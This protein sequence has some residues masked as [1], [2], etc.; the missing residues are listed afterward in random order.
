M[1]RNKMDY[2]IIIHPAEEG[3]YWVEVPALS[4]CY[5][6]GETIEESLVN[7]KDAIKSHICVLKEEGKR[8]PKDQTLVLSHIQV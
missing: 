4:G 6:Q 2:T 7:I 5:S 8:T 1:K 3:G